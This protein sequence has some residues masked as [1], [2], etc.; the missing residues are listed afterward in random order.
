[1]IKKR[2]NFGISVERE[3]YSR[4]NSTVPPALVEELGVALVVEAAYDATVADLLEAALLEDAPHPRVVGQG[5]AAHHLEVQ[6]L[7]AVRDQKLDGLAGVAAAAHGVGAYLYA[8]L[9]A[10]AP[11]IVEGG[12]ADGFAG[13]AVPGLD[14]EGL[15]ARVLPAGQVIAA[16][17]GEG[18]PDRRS[19]VPGGE[20]GVP[21]PLVGLL[22]VVL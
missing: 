22:D 21:V 7:E 14:D 9:A 1:M 18:D 11:K 6:G 20:L 13:F 19:T 4:R 15:D 5:R 2:S 8:D 12:Y 3:R 16:G 17:G 10:L